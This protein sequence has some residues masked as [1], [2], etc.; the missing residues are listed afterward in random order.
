[1]KLLMDI[2][3]K[4]GIED[5]I[6]STNIA[7]DKVFFDSR[8]VDKFGLFVAV[9]G[10]AVDGH[11][12]INRAINQGAVAIVCEEFPDEAIEGITYIKVKNSAKALGQI[13]ANYYDNPS[14]KIKLI[15]VT[16]TNGKTTT[17]TLLYGLFR[18]LG[19]K[20]GLLSTVVNKI[21]NLIVEATHT[22]PDALQLNALLSDMVEKKCTYCFMEVSSH[23]IHQH[24]ISG[25]KFTGG[26]FTNITHDHLD[27]HKTFDA[28]IKA[29]K[30]F[31]D[32]LPEN[33][34]ALIN[35]DDIHGE[36][37]VQNTRA[38]VSKFALQSQ[39]DFK[40]KI[41]ENQFS[42]LLLQIGPNEIWT[43]LIGRFNAYNILAS[44]AVATLVGEEPVDILTAISKLLPVEGRFQQVK[45]SNN[46]TG[47][48]D[49]AHTPDALENILKTIKEIRTGNEQVITVVGCGGDRDKE[50]RPIMASIACRYSDRVI[51]TSDN[52]RSEDPETI[53]NEM[54]AGV[55]I[56]HK[57]KTLA[58][59]NRKEA[60]E[61]ACSLADEGDIVLIAGKGH[62][63]YQEVN[64]ERLPFDD[65]EVL[66]E[67][68]NLLN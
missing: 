48:V 1:M 25:L 62:E 8:S 57:K 24:R 42:G 7:I 44:Y 43:Q 37:M 11:E 40:C 28:Y 16:G 27:Y 32:E 26:I 34:F 50:K 23:A 60:I 65:M 41:L 35:Q 61:T 38:R 20:V 33:A 21:D 13:A 68:L 6:G 66:N 54:Q 30:A 17:T 9:R 64:G 59:I 18:S 45:T 4:A 12:Y 15:G 47:I 55:E 5:I 58:I 31:F 53:L 56:V 19:Y 63:K 2:L 36:I 10:T 46:I 14:E 3:Y 51:L 49:Y 52:P 29:K 39:A 67:M 22:T